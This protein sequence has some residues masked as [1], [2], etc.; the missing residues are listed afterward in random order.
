MSPPLIL[1]PSCAPPP[2]RLAEAEPLYRQALKILDSVHGT[3]HTATHP[4]LINTASL[5]D[6]LGRESEAHDLLQLLKP[7]DGGAGGDAAS[8]RG[9]R[10]SSCVDQA[11]KAGKRS[12]GTGEKRGSSTGEKRGSSTRE[13]RGSGSGEPLASQPPATDPPAAAPDAAAAGGDTAAA[14]ATGRALAHNLSG[15]L[16]GLLGL[17]ATCIPV[18]PLGH[19]GSSHM[20]MPLMAIHPATIPAQPAELPASAAAAPQQ[21]AQQAG[22]P[23]S[24]RGSAAAGTGGRGSAPRTAPGPAAVSAKVLSAVSVARPPAAAYNRKTTENMLDCLED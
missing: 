8:K 1:S 19:T 9:R 22:Q 6:E 18:V 16:G 10:G 15:S 17:K 3:G 14:S 5:M 24:Q 7:V 13:K 4:V 2:P 11:S 23:A 12:S 20:N 21:Q